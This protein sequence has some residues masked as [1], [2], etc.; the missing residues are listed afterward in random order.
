V[1]RTAAALVLC[2]AAAALADEPAPLQPW[3]DR[4]TPAL[5]TKALDGRNVDLKDLHGR[6]VLVNFWATWCGPC[7]D[8][9]PSLVKLKEKLA[10]RPFELVAV[11][12]GEAPEKISRYLERAKLKLPVWLGP[13]DSI[14]T[15]WNVRGL[16]MTF[17]IDAQGRV[18][19]WA[20]G[21]RDWSEGESLK[22]IESLVAEAPRA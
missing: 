1:R 8:E 11:N 17:I 15:G 7:K 14:S 18:R 16:P 21:E 4:P 20:Y 13:E 5:A 2:A 3:G 19:Y 6:V 9:L 12:D 22:V 10:G